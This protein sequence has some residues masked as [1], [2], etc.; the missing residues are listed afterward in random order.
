MDYLNISAYYQK[1]SGLSDLSPQIRYGL[2]RISWPLLIGAVSLILSLIILLFI[3][4]PKIAEFEHA[5]QDYTKKLS[6]V[7]IAKKQSLEHSPLDALETFYESLPP[8]SSA[9][10]LI[11]RFIEA[12]RS[13]GITL[14]KVE[15]QLL[16]STSARL[17][18]YQIKAPVRADYVAVRKFMTEVLNT[19]PSA[20]L[21]EITLSRDGSNAQQVQVQMG[22]TFYLLRASS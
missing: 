7:S 1:I 11:S 5:Q 3:L 17:S 19:I 6:N 16:P 21:N 8:E 18:L 15:Y 20:A 2:S 4:L 10:Q 13:N 14:D 22:F 12:A 9:P